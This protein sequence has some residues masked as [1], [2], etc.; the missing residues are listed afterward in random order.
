MTTKEQIEIIAGEHGW[1]ARRYDIQHFLHLERKDEQVI[2][3][4]AEN[5]VALEKITTIEPH[6]IRD[7]KSGIIGVLAFIRRAR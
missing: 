2:I 7:L 5:D 4:F 6:Q 1:R 3:H